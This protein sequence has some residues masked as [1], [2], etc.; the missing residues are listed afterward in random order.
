MVSVEFVWVILKYTQL[1]H[2]LRLNTQE[3]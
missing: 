2:L 1:E 3:N